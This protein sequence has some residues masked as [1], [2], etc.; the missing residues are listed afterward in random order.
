MRNVLH[1][2]NDSVGKTGRTWL[3]PH[4]SDLLSVWQSVFHMMFISHK[5]FQHG[6]VWCQDN[7][8]IISHCRTS[9]WAAKKTRLFYLQLLQVLVLQWLFLIRCMIVFWNLTISS[10]IMLSPQPELK[11]IKGAG[12]PGGTGVRLWRDCLPEALGKQCLES[13]TTIERLEVKPQANTEQSVRDALHHT[14]FLWPFKS[15]AFG[16]SQIGCEIFRRI[17]CVFFVLKNIL[18]LREAG[19]IQLQIARRQL[20]TES[21]G[22]FWWNVG[23]TWNINNRK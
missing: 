10:S 11:S 15:K 21:Q 20:T 17:L 12:L 3:V 18:R 16:I 4:Q 8:H 13:S 9:T 7:T 23:M 6:R 14:V 1:H 22:M 5:Q 2:N 19:W